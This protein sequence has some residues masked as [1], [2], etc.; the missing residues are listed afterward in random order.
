ME[1]RYYRELKH[2][3][4]IVKEEENAKE[5]LA[6]YQARIL[7]KGKLSGIIPCNMRVINNENYL[8]YEINSMQSLRDR[9]AVR[10]MDYQQLTKLLG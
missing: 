10:G 5:K 7:E 6:S 8:Y 4:L 9:F 3:Y 1:Y 2:N